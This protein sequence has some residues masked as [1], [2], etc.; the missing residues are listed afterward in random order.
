MKTYVFKNIRQMKK[1]YNKKGNTYFFVYKGI[2]IDIKI[3]FDLQT[4]ADIVAGNI[5]AW[6]IKAHN[7][8]AFDMDVN[9]LSVARIE[10]CNISAANISATDITA[11][12]IIARHIDCFNITGSAID[13]TYIDAWEILAYN[14]DAYSIF[15]KHVCIAMNSLKCNDY[16]TN[17]KK[18]IIKCLNGKIKC[19]VKDAEKTKTKKN[20]KEVK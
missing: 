2:P 20:K 3:E 9:N 19:K 1:Y 11:G 4:T 15:F 18:H 14:I 12:D 5:R 10:C 13:C 17:V 8:S 16:Y 7:I 6:N